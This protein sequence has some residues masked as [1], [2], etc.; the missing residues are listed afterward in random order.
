MWAVIEKH[1]FS[2]RK[3][4]W[5]KESDESIPA[6]DRVYKTFFDSAGVQWVGTNER[7][8]RRPTG[9]LHFQATVEQGGT[10]MA[11]RRVS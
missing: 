9:S 10:C 1:L 6:S 8:Y 11:V 4:Y 7:I 2:L 3:G 5:S